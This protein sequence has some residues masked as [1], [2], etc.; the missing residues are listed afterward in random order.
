MKRRHVAFAACCVVVFL[1]TLRVQ[2]WTCQV[3]VLGNPADGSSL[4]ETS[5]RCLPGSGEAGANSGTLTVVMHP[6][7]LGGNFS[8]RMSVMLGRIWSGYS[9]VH[10]LL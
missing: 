10:H 5:V 1:S 6:A 7:M 4:T 3:H 8:G 9:L 2:A